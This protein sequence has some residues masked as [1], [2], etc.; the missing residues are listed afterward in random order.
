MPGFSPDPLAPGR[1]TPA[2]SL[3]DEKESVSTKFDWL[4]DLKTSLL[5]LFPPNL[6]GVGAN[7]ANV[8]PKPAPTLE[9]A[10]LLVAAKFEPN[11]EF[12]ALPAPE[13]WFVAPKPD[14]VVPL[15][16]ELELELKLFVF[17]LLDPKPVA[18]KAFW[19]ESV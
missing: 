8:L 15:L 14:A 6:V 9:P 19:L 2:F 17:W 11:W 7:G 5:K 13:N 4:V 16:A 12:P 1:Y 10:N 3:P 18:P